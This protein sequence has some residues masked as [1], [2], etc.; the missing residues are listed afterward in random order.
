M[1]QSSA[2]IGQPEEVFIE[3]LATIDAVHQV[4]WPISYIICRYDREILSAS[5]GRCYGLGQMLI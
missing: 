4:T 2:I 1:A 5:L 3:L